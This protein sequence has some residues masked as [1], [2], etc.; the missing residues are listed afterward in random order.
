MEEIQVDVRAIESKSLNILEKTEVKGEKGMNKALN[1]IWDR[2]LK[3]ER[4]VVDAR[5][6]TEQSILKLSK[7]LTSYKRLTASSPRATAK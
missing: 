5:K 3:L 4:K 7:Q 6:D 2:F 1:N